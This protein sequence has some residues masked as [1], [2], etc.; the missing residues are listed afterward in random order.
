MPVSP[1]KLVINQPIP[2]GVNLNENRYPS[3]SKVAI[4]ERIDKGIHS[5][6]PTIEG[7]RIGQ[8]YKNN[9]PILSSRVVEI[10]HI[11]HNSN[12]QLIPSQSQPLI[13]NHS[14]SSSPTVSQPMIN[15]T[16]RMPSNQVIT[17]GPINPFLTLNQPSGSR[18]SIS[19][20][21]QN[22]ALSPGINRKM[23]DT[24]NPNSSNQISIYTNNKQQLRSD[25]PNSH[26][27]EQHITGEKSNKQVSINLNTLQNRSELASVKQS[28]ISNFASG[29]E[30]TGS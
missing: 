29:G 30:N 14:R 21:E 13:M 28:Q 17:Q 20:G 5:A 1:P 18:L 24:F 27:S 10:G 23:F 15:T 16:Q 19:G 8:V 6:R 26:P 22:G 4:V 3:P 7:S 2:Y 9:Q 25:S 11:K 12:V